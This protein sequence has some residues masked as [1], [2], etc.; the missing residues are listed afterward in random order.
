MAWIEQVPEEQA[1]DELARIYQ[2]ARQRAGSVANILKVMSLRPQLLDSFLRM[3]LQLM[4]G[5]SS[6][7]RLERE[8]V[9]TVT[10][11]SNDCF[12]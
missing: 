1:E 10:S 2:D 6:L 9:A 5:E 4:Q 7:P 11:R 3:Y 8:L 12:Y